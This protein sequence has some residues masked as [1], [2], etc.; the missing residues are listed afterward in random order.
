MQVTAMDETG[1]A[2]ASKALPVIGIWGLA[3]PGTFPAPA[4]TPSAFNSNSA[5]TTQ[6]GASLL[7]ST[8]FRL[9]IFD[10][11]GD[12]RPDYHY[13]A[14]VFYGDS[15]SPSR[16]PASGGI[17]A[18]RGLGFHAN[19]AVSAA[20]ANARLLAASANQLLLSATAATDGVR[21]IALSD[22][23]A[24]MTS[25]MTGALTYGAGPNDTL[26]M[27]SGA[28]PSVSVGSQ[29]PV[30][31]AVLV[32]GPD[33]APVSGATIAFS[34]T[35]SAALSACANAASCSVFTDQSG[36]ASTRITP[37]TVG[38]ITI[39]AR[40]APASYSSPQQVQTTLLGLVSSS[41]DV[42]LASPK[43]W[44]PQGSTLDIPIT[45][46]ALTNGASTAGLNVAYTITAGSGSFSVPSNT[47]DSNGNSSTTLHVSA[48][49]AET[50]G[51]AC[52][53]ARGVT[54]CQNFQIFPVAASS[55][56]IQPVAG[57]S[58]SVSQ[59]TAFAP[60]S[61]RVTDSATPPDPVFGAAVNF[62]SI[63]GRAVN[64]QPIEWLTN[65]GITQNPMPVILASAQITASSDSNGLATA[66]PGPGAAQGPVLILGSATTGTA[67]QQFI[68]QSL[69]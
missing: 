42:S 5:D 37:L 53:T 65:T 17:F 57:T 32:L 39:V 33:G 61:V 63:I 12:G 25:T 51:N 6:L 66:Q 3:D 47:T 4:N 29:A 19:T 58:Q 43:I 18:V 30:P 9:G 28:N 62:Q 40:L 60:V 31:F 26:T 21:D 41:L 7:Q 11:R 23:A 8:N 20:G 64:D 15:A 69:P 24:S 38:V 59:Q 55:L 67:S 44:V 54:R 2:S 14:R 68:L 13:H 52:V 56:Q 34:V 27:I 35:P 48:I 45:T 36:H 16:V 10:F 50:D 46:H 22:P 49:A 1:A